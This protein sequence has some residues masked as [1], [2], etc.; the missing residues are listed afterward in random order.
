MLPKPSAQLA[1]RRLFRLGTAGWERPFMTAAN[2]FEIGQRVEK[3]HGAF[4]QGI[5]QGTESSNIIS[6]LVDGDKYIT[7]WHIGS[8]RPVEAIADDGKRCP[9][10]GQRLP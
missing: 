6:V 2:K 8:W 5:F 9:T 1:L 7:T 4:R 3:T 10:C